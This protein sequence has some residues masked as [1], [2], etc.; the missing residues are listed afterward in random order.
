MINYGAPDKKT[1]S[2]LGNV[3]NDTKER[4]LDFP[5]GPDVSEKTFFAQPVPKVEVYKKSAGQ[6]SLLVTPL[7]FVRQ[8]P[9]L[10]E[11]AE[12]IGAKEVKNHC[13]YMPRTMMPWHTNRDEPGQRT[14][15]TLTT[16]RALFRWMDNEGVLHTEEDVINGWTMRSFEV[17]QDYPMW[18]SI[19]TEKTRFSFGFLL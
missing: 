10:K 3:I 11:V 5:V 19:W 12:R 13:A 2:I 17:S 15:L 6:P 18:H 1:V 9:R 8:M 7:D 4:W 16:G 14:Y